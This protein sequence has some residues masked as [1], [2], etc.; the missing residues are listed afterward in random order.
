MC[1]SSAGTAKPPAALRA[2]PWAPAA[3]CAPGV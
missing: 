1:R 3:R 2:A